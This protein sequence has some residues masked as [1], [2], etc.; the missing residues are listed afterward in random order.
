MLD[1]RHGRKVLAA[2]LEVLAAEFP[3]SAAE[4]VFVAPTRLVAECASAVRTTV[5]EVRRAHRGC[6]RRTG[7]TQTF[8]GYATSMTLC[9]RMSVCTVSMSRYVQ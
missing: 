5:I 2:E 8:H 7:T 6:P 1:S 4:H 3:L 9:P